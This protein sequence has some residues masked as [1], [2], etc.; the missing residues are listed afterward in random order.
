MEDALGDHVVLNLV[1]KA[2]RGDVI[3]PEEAE[4][5]IKTRYSQ[6]ERVSFRIQPTGISADLG[7][8]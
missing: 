7:Y 1:E 3:E 8:D 2:A 5:L 4:D 6:M